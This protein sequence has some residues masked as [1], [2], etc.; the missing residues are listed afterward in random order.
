MTNAH[1]LTNEV[2]HPEEMVQCLCNWVHVQII[3]GCINGK[4]CKKLAQL[5]Q[6]LEKI[7]GGVV[8]A[9]GQLLEHSSFETVSEHHRTLLPCMF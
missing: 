3:D 8:S 6:E 4:I 7:G 2:K 5:E 9:I 1:S